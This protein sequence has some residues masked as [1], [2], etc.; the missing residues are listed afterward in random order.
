LPSL[1]RAGLLGQITQTVEGWQADWSANTGL[2]TAMCNSHQEAIVH[3]V[4]SATGGLRFHNLRH[5]YATWLITKGVPVNVV[6]KAM[7]HEQTSTTLDIYTHAPDDY[8]SHVA[9]AFKDP[10]VFLLYPEADEAAEL[11][12][13]DLGH[14][15]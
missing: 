4:K 15:L 2:Q 11:H 13:R 9:K 3:I 14:S 5:S 7:G 1:V 8:E 12:E 10:A 6:Q